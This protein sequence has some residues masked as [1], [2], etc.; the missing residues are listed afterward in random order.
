MKNNTN[1]R[2]KYW[3]TVNEKE[4]EIIEK[5]RVHEGTRKHNW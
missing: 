4:R 2:F 5:E 3:K 1:A